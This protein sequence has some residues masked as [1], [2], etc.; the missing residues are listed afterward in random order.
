MGLSWQQGPLA[1]GAIGRF[2][3]PEPLPERLLYIEP[4][5]RRM[6][7][8]FGGAWI[9]DSE[10]A[11]SASWPTAN[12]PPPCHFAFSCSA[13]HHK[14][15]MRSPQLVRTIFG[16]VPSAVARCSLSKRLPPIKPNPV[17]HRHSILLPHETTTDITKPLRVAARFLSL[18]LL[19]QQITFPTFASSSFHRTLGYSATLLLSL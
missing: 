8:R 12:V 9:A 15:S 5:R 3:V 19:V 16:P 14:P 10:N 13:R 6:R 2:L 7:V 4:L 17:L 1:P 18:R 11:T